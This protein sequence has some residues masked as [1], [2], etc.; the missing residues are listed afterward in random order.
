MKPLNL[1]AWFSFHSGFLFSLFS[2]HILP[3]I[4]GASHSTWDLRLSLHGSH[5][6][7]PFTCNL[8]L[9]LLFFGGCCLYETSS[10][11]VQFSFLVL[12]FSSRKLSLVP[13]IGFFGSH[14]QVFLQECVS[15]VDLPKCTKPVI[16]LP[17]SYASFKLLLSFFNSLVLTD[18]FCIAIFLC[19]TC[20][21]LSDCL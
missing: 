10:Q 8:L 17:V 7:S 13:R 18:S 9:L 3:S 21:W 15:F 14:I 6:L 12:L 20:S 5:P 16:I 1:E 4:T 19:I 11:Y 2:Q